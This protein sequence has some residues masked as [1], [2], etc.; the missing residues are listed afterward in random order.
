[1]ATILDRRGYMEAIARRSRILRDWLLFLETY[2][3]IL[4]PLSVKR[5]PAARADLGG[6]AAVKRLFW[7]DFRFMSV[8]QRPGSAGGGGSGRSAR[9]PPD[10]RATDRIAVS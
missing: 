3:V 8:D 1:M 2:P 9:W 4:T 10:R 6:D 7:N 5:T